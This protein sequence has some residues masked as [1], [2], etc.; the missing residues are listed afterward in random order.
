MIEPLYRCEMQPVHVTE[1]TG[2]DGRV[3]GRSTTYPINGRVIENYRGSHIGQFMH[4]G[5]GKL[6]IVLYLEG[7]KGSRIVDAR[8]LDPAVHEIWQEYWNS[9]NQKEKWKR[10]L[11][12]HRAWL[13][14]LFVATLAASIVEVVV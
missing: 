9:L 2:K 8:R 10:R 1:N 5:D 14:A 7:W 6:H 3:V 11:F 4:G 13:T 12:A